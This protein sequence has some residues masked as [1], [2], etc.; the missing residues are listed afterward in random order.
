MLDGLPDQHQYGLTDIVY[1]KESRP[2][3][4]PQKIFIIKV[5]LVIDCV[6][7]LRNESGHVASVDHCLYDIY[8]LR[9]QE[10]CIGEAANPFHALDRCP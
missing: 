10:P 3:C 8:H 9:R 7:D 4:D 6:R 1:L 5:D 2:R